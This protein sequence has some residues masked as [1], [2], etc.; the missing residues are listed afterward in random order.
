[1]RV[2]I[3]TLHRTE[4]VK[5]AI[6]KLSPQKI[7]F[8][9]DSSRKEKKDQNRIDEFLKNLKGLFGDVMPIEIIDQNSY[10]IAK[11]T[12]KVIEKIEYEY[13]QKNQ[14]Y[15][16]ISEGRKTMAIACMYAAYSR[17]SKVKG[18][19]YITEESND[20]LSLPVIPFQLAPT[21]KVILEEYKKGNTDIKKIAEITK[22]TQAMIYSHISDLK[23]SGYLSEDNKLTESGRI[24]I[25]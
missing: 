7:I 20:V 5:S 2:M 3:S 16:H 22:K 10:D 18:I 15:I 9:M 25:L 4:A 14:I 1:M 11:I 17:N 6:Q 19:Y 12:Q 24:A 23:N 13:E 8:V 21:K